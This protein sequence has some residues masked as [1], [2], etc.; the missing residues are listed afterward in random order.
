MLIR[1]YLAGALIGYAPSL[2]KNKWLWLKN[3]RHNIQCNDT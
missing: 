2:L 1:E 3:W